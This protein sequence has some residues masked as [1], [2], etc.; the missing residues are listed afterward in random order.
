MI[1][2]LCT[3]LEMEGYTVATAP[4]RH[5]AQD[6]VDAIQAEQADVI[7]MDV[8]LKNANGLD[9]LAQLQKSGATLPRVVM[10]SGMDV[11]DRCRAAGADGFL[12][13]P[14][15]PDELFAALQG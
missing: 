12:M 6:I 10:T 11:A 13:K 4:G 1:S 15:M 14:Y 5:P 9:V 3:L 2:V 8:H 7:L